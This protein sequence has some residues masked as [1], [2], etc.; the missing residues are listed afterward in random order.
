MELS[1]AAA[2]L[3]SLGYAHAD[4]RPPNILLDGDDRLKLADFDCV[5]KL[6]TRSD[7]S[8]PPWARLL[9]P[10]AGIGAGSFGFYSAR[11]E[12]FAIGS[13]LYCMTRGHEPYE[14][15]DPSLDLVDLFRHMKFP[16]L[17]NDPLDQIIDRCWRGHFECLKDLADETK[18]L[19]GGRELEP[20]GAFTAQ[21]CLER[22]KECQILVDEGLLVWD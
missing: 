10:E 5:A 16:P 15:E 7:G 8:A 18:T 1:N 19:G 9:G 3:E 17:G 4:I 13:V 2:W 12:Q 20:V 22:Q 14:N 6:G 21:Y 11:T